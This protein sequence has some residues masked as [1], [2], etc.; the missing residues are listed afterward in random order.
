MNVSPG[1]FVSDRIGAIVGSAFLSPVVFFA[2]AASFTAPA[3]TGWADDPVE[4]SNPKDAGVTGDAEVAKDAKVAKDAR[5]EQSDAPEIPDGDADAIFAFANEVMKNR[6]STLEEVK[7]SARS[8]VDAMDKIRR[9]DEVDLKTELKALNV[10]L[11]AFQFLANYDKSAKE[12]LDEL[13]DRLAKDDRKEIRRFVEMERLKS[14]IVT[15]NAASPEQRK[16][17]VGEVEAML[18]DAEIDRT[19]YSLVS[20]LARSLSYGENP[21]S[22][23]EL[24]ETLAE[25]LD[26]SDEEQWKSMAEKARGSARRLR[27]LGNPIEV[28]GT[29]AEGEPFDWSDY[30]GKVVLV[31]FWASWCGP[32]IGEIPNMKRALKAYPDDF[33]IVGINMDRTDAAMEKAV[34]KYDINW[35]NVVGDEENGMGWDHPMAS[36]YGVTAIPTAILV[37]RE[38]IVVSLAARGAELEEKLQELIG[39]PTKGSDDDEDA[40][41]DGTEASR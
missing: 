34:E 9:L 2:V 33:V 31:D 38:G 11:P 4:V 12:E 17:I 30:R 32:C 13:W 18:S 29:T 28:T 20:S 40:E 19:L 36:Y 35:V 10:Q 23:A 39:P 16:E 6:G 22:G 7:Q 14:R 27:L 15:I 3:S 5:A 8:V 24:Y 1:S 26:K 25:A 37:D 41:D 21:E